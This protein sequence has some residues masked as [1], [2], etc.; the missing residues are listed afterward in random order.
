M[1]IAEEIDRTIAKLALLKAD[2]SAK[3]EPIHA[4]GAWIFEGIFQRMN[5][6]IDDMIDMLR[7]ADIPLDQFIV[8]VN[9]EG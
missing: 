2:A 4:S 9:D 1:N 8:G 3:D 5:D 6:D 7:I